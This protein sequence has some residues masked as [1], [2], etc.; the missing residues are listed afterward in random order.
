[1]H[2]EKIHE[3]AMYINIIAIGKQYNLLLR[4]SYANVGGG[5]RTVG[6]MVLVCHRITQ[7]NMVM[8]LVCHRIRLYI[9]E[10]R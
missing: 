9:T 10:G 1:M 5:C 7:Y 2:I 3:Y 8:V 6:A 4:V